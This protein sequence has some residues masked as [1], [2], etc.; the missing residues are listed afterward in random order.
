MERESGL[1]CRR[2]AVTHDSRIKA[3]VAYR[4]DQGYIGPSP[5]PRV[6]KVVCSIT[7]QPPSVPVAFSLAGYY[8]G[9]P[10]LYIRF[11]KK[12]DRTE[13]G[14]RNKQRRHR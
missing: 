4:T 1:S 3:G 10:R 12:A 13:M 14:S 11:Q 6:G 2:H 8:F 5:Y 9:M 7:G